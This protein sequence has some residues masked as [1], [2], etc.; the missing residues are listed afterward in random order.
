MKPEHFLEK[1]PRFYPRVRV[2][3]MDENK[4]CGYITHTE[5]WVVFSRQNF[6]KNFVKEGG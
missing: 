6:D 2:V 1:K 5:R 3:F 4:V